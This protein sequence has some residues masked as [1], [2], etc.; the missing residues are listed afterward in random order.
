[1]S[2]GGR[3]RRALHRPVG[4]P[5][6]GRDDGQRARGLVR[7][8]A[9]PHRH[10][11]SRVLSWIAGRHWTGHRGRAAAGTR[12]RRSAT[13][14]ASSTATS[15]PS[16]STSPRGSA[17]PTSWPTGRGRAREIAEAV[18]ADP[19]ALARVLRGLALEGVARRGG[20]RALR[21]HRRSARVCAKACPARSAGRRSPA[22]S[23]TGRR[24]PGC[25]AP[26]PRAARRSSTSTASAS[27]STSAGDPE[28]EAAF[29]ASMADR[30]RR[31]AADVV[32][33]YDF[34]GLRELVDVGGGSGVLLEAILRRRRSCAASSSTGRRRSSGPARGLRPPASTTRECVVGDFFD[35][36]PPGADAYLLSRVIHDWDDA[37][38]RR[39]LTTC[40]EAMPAARGCCSSRRSCPSAP[41][42]APE[43]I[44][45]D[46]HMLMLFGARERTRRV[47]RLLAG[48]GLDT[49]ARRADGVA[50]RPERD[51]G[52]V[53]APPAE[54]A[55][56]GRCHTID[57]A[58]ALDHDQEPLRAA[59]PGRARALGR[60]AGPDRRA[61]PPP[62]DPRA[63][64]R[65]A[66][67]ASCAAPASCAPSAG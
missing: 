31:E 3:R 30:A 61:G 7:G 36:V 9:V 53:A 1:M 20:R 59:R 58:D 47:P 43:A 24:P 17:W 21:A 2:E 66:L 37:D 49:A 8:P 44:R 55:A 42:D 64:P 13:S 16:C 27:S 50:G 12:P 26:R 32:A 35:A 48:A 63:V 46:L 5:R 25:C 6:R 28:R 19:D 18:G 41:R 60:G 33:A 52:T 23:C 22:A 14:R 15:R 56:A 62:R 34:A 38:A 10:R 67:R 39:I 54:G 4:Q 45:M 40:R 51:R 11:R 29:Q 57:A 65:A